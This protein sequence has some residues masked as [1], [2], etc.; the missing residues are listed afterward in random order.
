MNLLLSL[1]QG[2]D[3]GIEVSSRWISLPVSVVVQFQWFLSKVSL[4]I[5]KLRNC[6]LLIH[7]AISLKWNEMLLL[8]QLN[9]WDEYSAFWSFSVYCFRI[10][11][12]TSLTCRLN[13][14]MQPRNTW[15]I[16]V[17]SFKIINII[18]PDISSLLSFYVEICLTSNPP[19]SVKKEISFVWGLKTSSS[20]WIPIPG[21]HP[22]TTYEN[23]EAKLLWWC[24]SLNLER[25]P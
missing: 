17:T 18:L 22:V 6:E 19:S 1:N 5:P 15:T 10:S 24:L 16:C 13:F 9:I 25:G 12:E 7:I 23:L 3:A 2:F 20:F 8:L 4:T 11:F 21:V 14:R